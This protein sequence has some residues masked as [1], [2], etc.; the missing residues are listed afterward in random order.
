MD[1][2]CDYDVEGV[3][4]DGL[5]KGYV[6]R[7]DLG[8]GFLDDY[9][10]PFEPE[11]LLDESV[12]LLGALSVLRKTPHVYVKVMGQVSGIVTKGDLE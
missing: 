1:P 11:L 10:N 6:K 4:Q 3:R 2:P 9:L 5:N 8:P 7:A 12:S